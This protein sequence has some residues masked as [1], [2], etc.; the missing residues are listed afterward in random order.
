MK[1]LI[2]IFISLFLFKELKGEVKWDGFNARIQGGLYADYIKM[3]N[4]DG[5][6]RTPKGVNAMFGWGIEYSFLLKK[7]IFLSLDFGF[8]YFDYILQNE[9]VKGNPMFTN[10]K[11]HALWLALIPIPYIHLGY[12]Y[13]D[14]LFTLNSVYY[15]GL[16]I[17]VRKAITYNVSTEFRWSWFIDRFTYNDGLHDMHFLFS[18]RYTF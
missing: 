12:T 17:T 4:E 16:G 14:W 9:I 3:K 13:E 5:T 7:H 10:S 18:L 1:K 2:L 15:W 8:P 11:F 6:Y